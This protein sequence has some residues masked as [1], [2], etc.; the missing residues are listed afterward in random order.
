[1]AWTDEASFRCE[2]QRAAALAEVFSFLVE[3]RSADVAAAAD[4]DVVSAPQSSAAPAPIDELIVVVVVP[5]NRDRFDLF[6]VRQR[7]K[8]RVRRLPQTRFR[9]EFD[10]FDAAPK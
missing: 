6:L 3:I 9:I 10:E 2:K 5:M 4:A 7:D 1:M 8:R